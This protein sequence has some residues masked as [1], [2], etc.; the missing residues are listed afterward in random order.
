[1]KKLLLSFCAFV[2]AH[3]AV[4][5]QC[6][7]VTCPSTLLLPPCNTTGIGPTVTAT[8]NYAAGISSRWYGPNGIPLFS[9]GTSTSIVRINHPGIYTVQFKDATSNCITTQ[10]LTVT[11]ASM[12]P[13]F[14]LTSVVNFSAACPGQTVDIH[15][16]NPNT[17][18][19]GGA[20]A[21]AMDLNKDDNIPPSFGPQ[22]DY[23]V[24][25]CGD[26]YMMAKDLSNLCIS[27]FDLF[28]EC[29]DP[30]TIRIGGPSNNT[31]C[32]G[33]S[34]TLTATGANYY[35]WSTGQTTQSI[36]ATPSVTSGVV[37]YSVSA[38]NHP[39]CPAVT[40]TYSL[41]V[42]DCMTTPT[43]TNTGVGLSE[44]NSFAQ[45][46]SLFPNP[47]S[48][49]CVLKA[50]SSD[51]FSYALFDIIGKEILKGT[52]TRS[53]TLDLSDLENGTYL[54]RLQTGKSA[55]YKKFVKN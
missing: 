29:V 7:V 26:V 45:S 44:N 33:S 55:A 13:L 21:F 37:I 43:E 6:P 52:F 49:H 41:T 42:V 2:L 5:A 20:I 1:M 28:I 39:Q 36:T 12:A 31:V 24:S 17:Q 46:I 48:S 9:T 35:S 22:L 8:S 47:A 19:A 18:P 51:E 34:A 50:S 15:F 14:Q 53:K 27:S 10:T 32:A 3:L 4:T 23:I 40:Q 11:G 30:P 54:L 25:E 38:T 16:D